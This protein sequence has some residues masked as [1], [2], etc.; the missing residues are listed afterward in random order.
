MIALKYDNLGII[1]ILMDYGGIAPE[2]RGED[3]IFL[4]RESD[5]VKEAVM[6]KGEVALSRVVWE[7]E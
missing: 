4:W 1:G 6:E 2:Y 5:L 3:D 7:E